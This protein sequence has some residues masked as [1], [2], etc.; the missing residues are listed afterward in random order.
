[1]D[2]K[3]KEYDEKEMGMPDLKLII[4]GDSAVGKSKYPK[5]ALLNFL[6]SSSDF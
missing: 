1:M 5:P 3:K 2:N 6:G 4:L